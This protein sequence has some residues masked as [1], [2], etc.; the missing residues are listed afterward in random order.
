VKKDLQLVQSLIASYQTAAGTSKP[1]YLVQID[2]ALNTCLGNL[3]AIMGAFH[4]SDQTLEATIAAA[5]GAAITVTTAIQALIPAPSLASASRVA[6]NNPK[7]QSEAMKTAFNLIVK[8]SY[9]TAV[10]K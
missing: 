4:V 9:P 8:K 10:I 1:G 3:T 6:L 2:A 7:D 5:L